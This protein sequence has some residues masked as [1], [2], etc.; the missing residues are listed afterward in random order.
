MKK[1]HF[2]TLIVFALSITL[3]LS[4]FSQ[5]HQY[6]IITGKIIPE[7]G[8]S[9]VSSVQIIK[10]NLSPVVSEIPVHGR[11]RLELDFNAEYK[12]TF[13]RKGHLPKVIQIN[14]QV[15][16][17][18]M[19]RSTT[20]PRFLMAVK[21]YQDDPETVNLASG[22]QVQQIS[23]SPENDCFA[24]EKTVYDVEYV[25]R[26]SST[27]NQTTHYHDNKSRMQVYQIF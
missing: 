8:L 16:Q 10:N 23:Y 21:L 7:S 20:L 9:E 22:N 24:K 27:S 12:L 3:H 2:K 5:N 6:F 18:V 26:I 25:D 19:L 1:D 11:F 17:E 4:A 13:N 14:T 15:P